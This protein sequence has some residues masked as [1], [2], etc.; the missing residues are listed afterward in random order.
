MTKKM[1]ASWRLHE[2]LE[3][4]CIHS[5]AELMPKLAERGIHLSRMQVYRLVT[6]LP[7]RVSLDILAALCDIL[8]C[9]PNDL[10][11]VKVVNQQIRR[12]LAVG[13]G[14]SLQGRVTP[15]RVKIRRPPPA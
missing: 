11:S 14:P 5:S 2:R 8:N 7:Q 6:Q 10:I 15:L 3:S 13:E 12:P 9:T 4:Q 1:A